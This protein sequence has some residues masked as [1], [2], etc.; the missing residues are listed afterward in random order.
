MV[1]IIREHYADIE[2][3]L[4]VLYNHIHDIFAI[5]YNVCYLTQILLT[6]NFTIEYV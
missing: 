2:R 1:V 6:Y 3:E 4:K 5:F